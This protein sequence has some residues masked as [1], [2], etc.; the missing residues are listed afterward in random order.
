MFSKRDDFA[1]VP[2]GFRG[3]AAP[4]PGA[5]VSQRRAIRAPAIVVRFRGCFLERRALLVKEQLAGHLRIA[6]AQGCLALA[7]ARYPRT[8]MQLLRKVSR[9]R[10]EVG[11]PKAVPGLKVVNRSVFSMLRRRASFEAPSSLT[12]V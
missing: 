11:C 2:Q 9:M 3:C 10:P 4:R 6:L 8:S 12:I 1:G 7:P 5:T